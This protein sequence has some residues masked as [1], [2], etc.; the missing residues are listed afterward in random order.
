[1]RPVCWSRRTSVAGRRTSAI[2]L[3]YDTCHRSI[4][5]YAA[6]MRADSVD[7]SW[8]LRERCPLC[9]DRG[10]IGEL[11]PYGRGVVEL[12]PYREEWVLVARFRCNRTRGTFSLLPLELAPYH[13]YTVPTMLWALMFC[14][15]MFS[16]PGKPLD[17]VL[18][19][20]DSDRPVTMYLV[21]CWARMVIRG[22]RRSHTTLARLHDLRGVRSESGFRGAVSEVDAYL[23][24]CC[25]RGPPLAVLPI[26]RGFVELAQGPR[27]LF[28]TAS[29]DRARGR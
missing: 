18:E 19:K 29:Q 13:V 10:C 6:A 15:V 3:P 16:E 8:V 11:T 24:A 23:T 12:F 4:W 14:H 26:L 20:L 17:A 1:M 7:F 5:E 27:F 2:Q 9:G 21:R 22:F 25:A 28:G